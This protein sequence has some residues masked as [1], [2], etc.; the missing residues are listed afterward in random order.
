MYTATSPQENWNDLGRIL[1]KYLLTASVP[2]MANSVIQAGGK[3]SNDKYF[4]ILNEYKEKNDKKI[5]YYLFNTAWGNLMIEGLTDV[6]MQ[7]LLGTQA[8]MES[9][10]TRSEKY[11]R[12]LNDMFGTHD[13]DNDLTAIIASFFDLLK[14]YLCRNM[15]FL[16]EAVKSQSVDAVMT[17]SEE[18][19]AA[20]RLRHDKS[21]DETRK[22]YIPFE[23]QPY[24]KSLLEQI[25]E[26]AKDMKS[27][28]KAQHYLVVAELIH[29]LFIYVY[30][31][32]FV[33]KWP[34]VKGVYFKDSP[35]FRFGRDHNLY[36]FLST[37]DYIK[38]FREV[39][40]ASKKS[41][42]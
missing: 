29:T 10:R 4:Q 8:D 36:S 35:A 3:F 25:H 38:V 42:D 22:Y 31:V 37:A 1:K 34:G 21:E 26:I 15:L 24:T 6:F 33:H 27:H 2:L 32:E 30:M 23:E 19:Y 13:G 40:E 39:E 18:I 14:D 9:Y 28:P 41:D 20:R 7:R 5:P 16:P 11:L 12:V 17:A